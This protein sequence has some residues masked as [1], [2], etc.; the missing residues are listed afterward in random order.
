MPAIKRA[1]I[2]VSDKRGLLDLARPMASMGIQI[3]STGGTAAA[4]QKGDVAVLPVDQVTGFPE[5]LDGRIKTLHPHVHGGILAR[6]ELDHMAQLAAHGIQPID[7]VVVNLYPFRETVAKPNV[8]VDDAIEQIDI[9]GPAMIRSAAKNHTYVAVVVDPDDYPMILKELN[10]QAG[11]I[12]PTL[13]LYL[14]QKAF[15]HTAAYDAAIADY[16]SRLRVKSDR[17]ME[18]GTEPS[19]FGNN[20]IIPLTKRQDLRYGENPHQRAALY[21]EIGGRSSGVVFSDVF[22]GK[23]LSFNNILDLDAAW[24]LV[25]EF[26]DPAAVIIKHNNP[27]GAAVADTLREAYIKAHET[28][29]VSAFGS[30]LA[31]NRTVDETLADEIVKTFV[32]ALIAPDYAPAALEIFRTKKNLR[33]L[34]CRTDAA[35][36]SDMEL[37]YRRVNGG[38]LIQ[39]RDRYA[40]SERDLNTVTRRTPAP[41]EVKALLF[42]W[43][44]VKHVKSNAIVYAFSDRTAGIGAGQMSRVDSVRLGAQKAPRS[45]Q[46]SVLAS[47]AF[48]PF[49]DGIDEAAKAGITAVIQPGG[50]IRDQEVIA[51][52]DELD[53]AMVFT[54]I[55]HFRH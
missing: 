48:F 45:L 16:M 44:V 13:R 49:R 41:A 5:M 39:D 47:D 2:S 55:R 6:R 27:C 17:S 26:A 51:A 9:G 34:Q 23:E 33:V 3:I 7:L 29:P 15:A 31:F 46:G 38:F 42:A 14:A 36:S 35:A 20:R 8:S 32:E 28:D 52:C 24:N 1:L 40:L 22:Q 10:E 12:S 50:S 30:V 54:G 11:E 4:L 19:P 53:L 37:D 43:K 21:A 25:G 18:V